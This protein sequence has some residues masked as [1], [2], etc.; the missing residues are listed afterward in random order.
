MTSPSRLLLI[1]MS[2]AFAVCILGLILGMLYSL[3]ESLFRHQALEI[4]LSRSIPYYKALGLLG[5]LGMLLF[6]VF[7]FFQI[8][9]KGNK[10][11]R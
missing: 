7:L 3:Y 5:I 2:T 4:I 10:K 9:E 1:S 6:F 8:S 11:P